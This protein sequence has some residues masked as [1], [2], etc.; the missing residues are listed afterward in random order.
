MK[1]L[2]MRVAAVALMLLGPVA[3]GAQD[4]PQPGNLQPASGYSMQQLDQ[5]LAPVALYPDPL[6]T[7]I[8]TAATYPLEIVQADRWLSDPNNAALAGDQLTAA[9]RGQDWDP[10]VKSLVPFPP[11]LKMMS[12]QLDWMQQ[13]GNAFISQQADVMNEVQALRRQ[14]DANGKLASGPQATVTQ[15]DGAI[16]IQPTDPNS[17]SIPAYNPAA[18]FGPW[19]YPGYP[20][21]NFAPAGYEDAVAPDDG[22]YW[23][24]PLLIVGAL[25]FWDPIDWRHHSVHFDRDRF[26]RLIAGHP[27]V[28]GDLWQHDPLHR[29]GVA[30]P[31]AQLQ[32]RFRPDRVVGAAPGRDFRGFAPPAAP[33]PQIIRTQVP[34]STFAPRQIA[35]GAPAAFGAAASGEQARRE[36]DRG[37]ASRKTSAPAQRA[38]PVRPPQEEGGRGEHR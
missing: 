13:L 3:A 33:L 31:T 12:D 16:A 25:W 34:A 28:G 22:L 27:F 24:P 6:L 35:P 9:L 30:Y 29:R 20:P 15:D 7:S 38:A 36:A 19:P 17:L 14:A 8:M 10:S 37:R 26:N 5:I 2:S 32:Q 11:I 1:P 4:A 21:D 23:G 18:V